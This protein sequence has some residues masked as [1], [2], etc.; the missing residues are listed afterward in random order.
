MKKVLPLLLFVLLVFASCQRGPAIYQMSES[1][2]EM[3]ENAEKFA[4]ETVKRSRHYTEE[5]WKIT[6]DQFEAM[7]KDYVDKRNQ[8]DEEEL[9]RADSARLVFTEAVA[10]NGSLELA[11]Q[12]KEIFHKICD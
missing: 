4:K 5:D 8:M 9:F 1:P 7:A 3:A 12:T 11:L 10:K 2:K 6:F